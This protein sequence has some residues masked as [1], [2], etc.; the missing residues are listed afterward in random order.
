MPNGSF[1]ILIV[2]DSAA[3]RRILKNTISSD[4]RLEVAGMASNG[5]TA[6]TCIQQLKPDL[7]V[8]DAEM[9]GMTRFAALAELRKLNPHLPVIL[10]SD[11]A[12]GVALARLDAL[13][14]GANDYLSKKG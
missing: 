9:P 10:L 5:D 11:L 7:V 4:A 3:A 12:F 2:D 1:R 6:L 8:L 13:S 14:L